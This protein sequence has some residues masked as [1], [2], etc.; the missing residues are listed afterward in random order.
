MEIN[1]TQMNSWRF[2]TPKMFANASPT[3]CLPRRPECEMSNFS[4]HNGLTANLVNIN[5]QRLS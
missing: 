1:K 3:L 4:T 5:H 2:V